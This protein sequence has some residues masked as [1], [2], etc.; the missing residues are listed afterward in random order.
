MTSNNLVQLTD[1]EFDSAIS[2]NP[3][4]LV[5]FWAEWCY[6][7]KVIA[8]L[9]EEMAK[10]Y[11]GNLVCAKLNIDDNQATPAKFSITGIPTV[12]IFKDGKLVERIVGAVSKDH[13]EGK[14][15]N[16]L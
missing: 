14:I 8:P 4:V 1:S 13:L 10:A 11:H 12:L 2:S 15:K 7:C 9:I 5:D 3:L 16:Y 6:P